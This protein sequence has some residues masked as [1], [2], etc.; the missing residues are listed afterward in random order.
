MQ[1]WTWTAHDF[2]GFSRYFDFHPAPY[3]PDVQGVIPVWG[4][5]TI[6]ASSVPG[7][8]VNERVFGYLAMARYVLLPVDISDIN[9]FSFCISRPHL[10]P[11]TKLTV[12]WV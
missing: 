1:L 8:N 9:Q 12:F 7:I 2:C 10:P 5:G 4:F 3:T 11:G 6:V